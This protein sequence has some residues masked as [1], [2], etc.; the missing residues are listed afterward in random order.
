MSDDLFDFG[1]RVDRYA[2]MGNPV[3]HSKSPLIHSLFARQTGQSIEY[4]AIQ[5]DIGGFAQAVGNFSASGAKGV[6]VTVPFKEE[7]WALVAERSDRAQLAGAVN[8]IKFNK[9]GH[10]GDNTDGVGLVNDLQ[11]NHGFALQ[12]KRV[13]IMGAGGAARG[14]I[15]PILTEQVAA[16]VIANR[17]PDKAVALATHFAKV[18]KITGSG[19]SQLQ[20]MQFDLVLNATAASLQGE[21]PPLPGDILTDAAMCYDLMY[22]A[23]PTTFMGWARQHGASVISDGLGMLVEQAAESFHLWRG[24]RPQTQPVIRAIRDQLNAKS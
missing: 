9:H 24:V 8:T 3:A 5:V 1:E 22:G 7:A 6:N 19:Y 2:V 4:T 11:I 13:L 14:I 18:G 21:M 10:Y 20:G 23:K 15:S 12:G 17:T 16:M